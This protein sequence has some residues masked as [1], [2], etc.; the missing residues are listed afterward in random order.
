MFI[1]R[2]Y[3]INIQSPKDF[4]AFLDMESYEIPWYIKDPRF[5]DK[6]TKRMADKT[7]SEQVYI[8]NHFIDTVANRWNYIIIDT[9]TNGLNNFGESL[10]FQIA[11]IAYKDGVAYEELNMYI[12]DIHVPEDI[13]TLTHTDPE[14]LAKGQSISSAIADL[15]LFIEK[16]WENGELPLL[17]AHNASFDVSVL[18][19]LYLKAVVDEGYYIQDLPDHIQVYDTK[20]L[21]QFYLWN[22]L[23][24]T[25]LSYSIEY[26]CND[27]FQLP[28]DDSQAHNALYDCVLL[29]SL[30]IALVDTYGKTRERYQYFMDDIHQT[31]SWMA[32]IHSAKENEKTEE[33]TKIAEKFIYTF[34]TFLIS[35][36][37]LRKVKD[38]LT[39]E[40]Y[41]NPNFDNVILENKMRYVVKDNDRIPN[42]KYYKT[43]YPKEANEEFFVYVEEYDSYFLVKPYLSFFSDE[44]EKVYRSVFMNKDAQDDKNIFT[45]LQ[46]Y[47]SYQDTLKKS[48]FELKKL[49]TILNF[50][51]EDI[52][53]LCGK[54]IITGMYV[55][56]YHPGAI[57]L[58]KTLNIEAVVADKIKEEAELYKYNDSAYFYLKGYPSHY[59]F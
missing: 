7:P 42:E 40:Y 24:I 52:A 10:P 16:Y 44:E 33:L 13:L 8:F 6:G 43:F 29:Q 49:L 56:T 55:E 39:I 2:L 23:G 14:E 11:A 9:E 59:Y 15:F 5:S 22:V 50:F 28:R 57:R 37:N 31:K 12:K 54:D 41:E 4:G 19:N 3:D 51:K 45:L 25:D 27:F 17:F 21:F 38:M 53:Y 26:L 35:K 58:P 34:K 18:N 46:S 1:K 36:M 48:Y 32:E 47:F 30:I 20:E